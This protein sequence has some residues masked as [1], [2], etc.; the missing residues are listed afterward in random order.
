M[1]FLSLIQDLLI[2][3]LGVGPS[4][5]FTSHLGDGHTVKVENH[6]SRTQKTCLQP[7]GLLSDIT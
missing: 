3:T 5:L 6:F 4:N 2:G 7:S 1:Q